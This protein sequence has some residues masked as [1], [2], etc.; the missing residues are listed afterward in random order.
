MT[1][2]SDGII[3]SSFR[4][5]SGFVFVRDGTVYRQL[6]EV[7]RENFDHLI[8]SGL[9]RALTEAGLMVAH[10]EVG[11]D[12]AQ[13]QD[14]YK[15]LRP[16][17]I[18]FISYPYEWCFSQLKNAALATLAIQKRAF[19]FGMTLKDSS[20]FN[21]QFVGC[22]P[23]LIDTLSFEKYRKGQAWVAYRQFCQHFLGPLALMAYRDVRLSQLLRIYIDGVGLDLVSKLLPGSTWFNFSVLSHIHI[24]AR[25]QLHFADKVVKVEAPKMSKFGFMGIID[26]LE[27]AVGKMKWK[28]K[29]T[30]WGG[31]Y[32]NTNYSDVA[33]S[34]KKRITGE[35]LER[36][37]PTVTWDM[38]ANTGVFSR[39]AAGMGSQT[40]SFDVDPAAVEKNYLES[41]DKKEKNI[42]P[43]VLDLTNP[44][45]PIGWEN[46]E[47][48]SLLERGPADTVLALALIHHL[49]IANNLSFGK[50]ADFFRKI[51]QWLI[52]E[53]VPKSDSQVQRMLTTR[54]DIF[55]DYGEGAFEDAFGRFFTIERSVKIKDLPRT[56]YLMRKDR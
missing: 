8:D 7:Y 47:R 43:L 53:F 46:Q 44:S 2:T 33:M 9:Y 48:R 22:R 18:D 6:N 4:D 13:T 26:S 24:H 37:R 28:P 21:I 23:V 20:A 49:A 55:S 34:E 56:L 30:Q 12:L 39:I 14:A 15:I 3:P 29:G 35:F 19:D 11:I 10:E 16:E 17:K 40:I 1:V 25:S 42:L 51:C 45:G 38:G 50:I 31:Y 5:P 32:E 52:I 54:E 41:V 36:A 27:T